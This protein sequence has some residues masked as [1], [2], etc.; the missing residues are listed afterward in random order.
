M[1]PS[2]VVFCMFE[3]CVHNMEGICTKAE[4]DI[5]ETCTNYEPYGLD[6]NEKEDKE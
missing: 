2:T 3:D 5:Y 1:K 4:I 6:E